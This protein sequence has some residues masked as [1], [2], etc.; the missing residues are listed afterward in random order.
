MLTGCANMLFSGW[1]AKT[2]S[3][4]IEVVSET[5]Y[6]MD[7]KMGKEKQR[8]D[9]QTKTKILIVDD[10]HVLRRGLITLESKPV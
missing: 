5:D 2:G 10:H 7:Y 9:S 1:T 8:D 4:F 6:S 3:D